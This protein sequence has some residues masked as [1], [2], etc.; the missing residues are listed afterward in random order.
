MKKQQ[1]RNLTI[2]RK[3]QMGLNIKKA[4]MVFLYQLG[5]DPKNKLY[6]FPI[7]LKT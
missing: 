6:K 7:I 5:E 4:M 1:T 3:K 2:N